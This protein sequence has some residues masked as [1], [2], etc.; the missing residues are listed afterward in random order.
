MSEDQRAINARQRKVIATQKEI[1]KK[2][3]KACIEAKEYMQA[4]AQYIP[5]RGGVKGELAEKRL[6][7]AL[8]LPEEKKL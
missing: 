4:T 5:E 3:R 2:M 8:F 1:I 6:D 7:Q